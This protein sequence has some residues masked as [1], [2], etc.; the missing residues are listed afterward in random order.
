MPDALQ[1]QLQQLVRGLGRCEPDLRDLVY[2]LV[3]MPQYVA[4]CAA[5]LPPNPAGALGTF[6]VTVP[7]ET[8]TVAG[9]AFRIVWAWRR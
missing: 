3:Y 9:D 5:D 1:L 7:T 2:N 8:A 6:A 4:R